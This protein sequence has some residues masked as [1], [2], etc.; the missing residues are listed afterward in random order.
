MS[1]PRPGSYVREKKSKKKK[2]SVSRKPLGEKVGKP[3]RISRRAGAVNVWSWRGALDLP[4]RVRECRHQWGGSR[5][6]SQ[7]VFQPAGGLGMARRA[8]N[9]NKDFGHQLVT[10][11]ADSLHVK[12]TGHSSVISAPLFRYFDEPDV[13]LE[14]LGTPN[15]R[16]EPRCLCHG[17]RTPPLVGRSRTALQYISRTRVDLL[18]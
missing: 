5:L 11:R 3:H 7:G 9:S 6:T 16:F 13:S 1:P 8:H 17:L 4:G 14:F 12:R 18:H 15:R 10:V 2:R